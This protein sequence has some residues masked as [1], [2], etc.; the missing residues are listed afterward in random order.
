[1]ATT[2]EPE[3]QPLPPDDEGY[4]FTDEQH[5]VETLTRVA[6]DQVARRARFFE[7]FLVPVFLL[8]VALWSVGACVLLN[9]ELGVLA[10]LVGLGGLVV[11]M[12]REVRLVARIE[13]HKLCFRCAYPLGEVG[14]DGDGRGVCPECGAPFLAAYYRRPPPTYVRGAA[15]D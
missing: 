7:A 15:A 14:L 11:Y 1:M 4:C 2:S 13:Q 6:R 8:L 9:P 5:F 12:S 10:L 3:R